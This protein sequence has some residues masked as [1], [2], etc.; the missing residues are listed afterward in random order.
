MHKAITIIQFKLEAEIIKNRHKFEM[1]DRLLLDKINFDTKTVRIKDKEYPLLDWNFPTINRKNPYDFTAQES[2]VI[3]KLVVS[4]Q[5]SEK[6]QKHIRFLYTNG[7]LYL[8]YNSNLLFHGC[9]LLNNNGKLHELSIRNKKYKGKRLMDKFDQLARQGYFS[10]DPECKNYGKDIL[11]YLWCGVDSP[12]FGKTKM[13]NFERYFIADEETHQ[14]KKNRYYELREDRETCEMILEEF[15][16]DSQKSHIING[17][18][19]VKANKGES[20]IKGDNKLIVIDGGLSKAYQSVTGIA[21]Y[22]LIYD[23]YGM[24]LVSHEPFESAE[25][26][27]RTDSEIVST[28]VHREV[29]KRRLR[30]YDTDTGKILNKHISALKD[31]LYAY[32]QG[33]IKQNTQ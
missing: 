21:G 32:K 9:I 3:Q 18:V 25:K 16:L 24:Q 19:P 5:N 20:P 26:S 17:H 27:I 14:E 2:E 33:Y 8:T 12:L 13:A 30:V 29:V 31:L 10:S 6:L 15:G 11:W 23:S 4:F 7:S 1:D 28:D 22:T